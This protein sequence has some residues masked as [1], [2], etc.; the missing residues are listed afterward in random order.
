MIRHPLNHKSLKSVEH[1]KCQ[2]DCYFFF[3]GQNREQN[4]KMY[5]CKGPC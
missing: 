1:I 4:Q 5:V 2:I 3:K